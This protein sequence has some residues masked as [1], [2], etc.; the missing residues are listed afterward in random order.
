VR[1]YKQLEA[2]ERL[3]S[4]EGARP[5]RPTTDPPRFEDRV[6]AHALLCMLAYPVRLEMEKRLAELLFVDDAL[7]ASADPI[8][9]ARRSQRAT[10]KAASKRTDDG[11]TVSSF[12]DL[13]GAPATSPATAS[14][15]PATRSASTSS[16]NKPHSDAAPSNS[17]RSTRP[18][19]SQNTTIQPARSRSPSGI[20]R[21]KAKNFGLN[22]TV[23][24]MYR[25]S[26]LISSS[27]CAHRRRSRPG[28]G[29]G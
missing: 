3:P 14:A 9:P 12:R 22:W 13:L 28:S 6:R 29:L 26:R 16:P 17:S 15:S 18:A 5:A 21:L 24:E 10:D 8:A 11:L 25:H 20:Q 23:T 2:A 7:L 1:A 19:C 27:P 4:D